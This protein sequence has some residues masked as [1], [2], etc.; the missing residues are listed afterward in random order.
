MHNYFLQECR[1][2][3]DKALPGNL[4]HRDRE[5][6]FVFI[7]TVSCVQDEISQSF[8]SHITQS[9][10]HIYNFTFLINLF[11]SYVRPFSDP[12]L[13]MWAPSS[14]SSVISFPSHFEAQVASWLFSSPAPSGFCLFIVCSV[15]VCEH[16]KVSRDGDSH[17]LLFCC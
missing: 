17:F 4:I 16:G 12:L 9:Q 5:N 1:V 10:S 15:C 11:D 13:W 3:Q 2:I 6:T 8:I 7:C 14:G